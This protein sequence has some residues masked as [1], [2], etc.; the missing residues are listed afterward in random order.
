VLA[1]TCLRACVDAF[2]WRILFANTQR[3][4]IPIFAMAPPMISPRVTNAPR[5]TQRSRLPNGNPNPASDRRKLQLCSFFFFNAASSS[6]TRA[7][8]SAA[9]RS[10]PSNWLVLGLA[11]KVSKESTPNSGGTLPR[12]PTVSAPYCRARTR[13]SGSGSYSTQH[14]LFRWDLKFRS[15]PSTQPN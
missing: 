10:S 11:P 9:R 12:S 6:A 7:A 3:E 13:V 1:G 4:G 5:Q 8:S 15:N 14:N 2:L